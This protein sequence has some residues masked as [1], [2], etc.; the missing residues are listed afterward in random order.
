MKCDGNKCKTQ[1]YPQQSPLLN[2][3]GDVSGMWAMMGP[4]VQQQLANMPQE[5]KDLLSQ[6]E[7]RVIKKEPEIRVVITGDTSN[8]KIVEMMRNMFSS[9]SGTLPNVVGMLGAR[10]KVYE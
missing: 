10:V 1:I 8:P 3:G 7:V 4:M 6:I 9:L 2:S 5:Q